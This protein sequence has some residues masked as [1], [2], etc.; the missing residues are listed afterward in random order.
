MKDEENHERRRDHLKPMTPEEGV[1]R[2]LEQREPSVAKS[3]FQNNQ[4]TIE[5]FLSWCRDEGIENLNELTGRRIADYVHHRRQDVKPISLQ[6]ELSAVRLALAYWAD[7]DAVEPGLRE[8]V[9]APEVAD[10][11]KARDVKVDTEVAEEIL[12]FL[13]RYRRATR[14]H[15]VLALW[16]QTGIRLGAIRGF[17]LRDRRPDDQALAIKHRPEEDTPLKNGREGERWVWLGEGLYDLVQE[18]IDIHRIDVRDEYGRQPLFTTRQ[19]RVSDSTLR[20]LSYR[21]TQPCRW[22][23]C[24]HGREQES[25]EAYG[26]PNTPSKCPSTRSPHGWRRGSITDHL[27]RGVSPEVVSERMNVSLEVLYRHYD[28][29]QPDEKMA[30]RR[31]H[32]QEK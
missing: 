15:V 10:G 19:G 12:G 6:K 1:E 31:E 17:D 9:H 4:T 22:D 20:D 30:V 16:W 27:A 21:W 26:T 24:P 13:E 7:I 23:E 25:C 14:E 32:L 11:A 3:T 2:W 5:Q 18:Y 8:R 28:A 29:R